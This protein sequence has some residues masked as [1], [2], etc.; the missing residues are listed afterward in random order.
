M[1]GLYP[2][3]ACPFLKRNEGGEME[4][5]IGGVEGGKTLARM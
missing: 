1:L 2:W 3:E 5:R 4:D